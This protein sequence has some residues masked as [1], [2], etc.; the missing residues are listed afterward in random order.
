M[1]NS[2]GAVTDGAKRGGY[3]NIRNRIIGTAI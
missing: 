1:R 3:G 2:F